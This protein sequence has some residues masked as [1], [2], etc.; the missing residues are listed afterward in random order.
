VAKGV[1][2]HRTTG[3]WGPTADEDGKPARARYS[4]GCEKFAA[5]GQHTGWGRRVTVPTTP[6]ENERILHIALD[7][8]PRERLAE[9]F[10]RLWEEVGANTSNSSVRESLRALRQRTEELSRDGGD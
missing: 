4:W 3:L 5:K 9:M 6:G 1:T 2:I 10:R 8:L 7:Y